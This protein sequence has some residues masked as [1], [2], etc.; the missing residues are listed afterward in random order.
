LSRRTTGNKDIM[1]TTFGQEAL[2]DDFDVDFIYSHIHWSEDLGIGPFTLAEARKRCTAAGTGDALREALSF[3]L[4]LESRLEL[5]QLLGE[6]WS[7]F[8]TVWQHAEQLQSLLKSASEEQLLIMMTPQEQ[9]MRD[10]LPAE[11]DVYRGCYHRNIHGLTW[12]LERDVA[13]SFPFAKSFHLEAPPL[14][15][16]ARLRRRQSVV[17]IG[18]AGPTILGWKPI[19]VGVELL[20]PSSF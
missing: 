20:R 11:F 5:L 2:L 4:G 15:V 9:A 14:L 17:K 13:A 8:H 19:P 12:S 1:D 16:S 18:D 3:E 6:Q 7:R 10:E